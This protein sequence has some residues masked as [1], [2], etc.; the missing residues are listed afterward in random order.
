M[1]VKFI[2]YFSVTSFKLSFVKHVLN[3]HLSQYFENHKLFIGNETVTRGYCSI[4]F[5]VNKLCLN[6]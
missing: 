3:R 2:N 4:A 1:G 5:T 6:I